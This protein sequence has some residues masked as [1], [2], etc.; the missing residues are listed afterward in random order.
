M[1]AELIFLGSGTSSGVPMIGCDC[2]VCTSDDPRDT[3]TRPSVLLRV[4]DPTLEIDEADWRINPEQ[5]GHR[6]YLID[7]GPDL[8]EQLLR[9]R[10]SR[11]DGVL[12]THNHADHVFGLDEL[13]RF[14]IGGDPQPVPLYLEHTTLDS[15][16]RMFGYIFESE[17]NLNRSFIPKLATHLIEPLGGFTLAGGLRVLPL[18]LMHG[19][20][21]ILGFRF[22][23]P[24]GRAIAYCTDCSSVPDASVPHLD[25]LDVLVMDGLRYLPHPTHMDVLEAADFILDRGATLGLLTHIAHDC[26][27]A[28]LA[29]KLPEPVAPAF[30]GLRVAFA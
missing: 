7:T 23:V 26:G 29:E 11:I 8:R 4:P 19:R 12:Y 18:R 27:H 9:E 2:P 20:Q 15:F 30:D 5:A 28:G 3:R 25:G 1:P 10:I 14:S 22:D 6:Q 16:K 17:K 24:G 21:P 13:R